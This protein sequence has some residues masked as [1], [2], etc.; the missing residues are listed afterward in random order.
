MT[1]HTSDH[2]RTYFFSCSRFFLVVSSLFLAFL[3]AACSL[4]GGST[5]TIPTTTSG[6]TPTATH[7]TSAPV[8]SLITYT[9]NGFRVGYP[10]RWTMEKASPSAALYRL[11]RPDTHNRVHRYGHAQP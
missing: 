2:H 3:L 8:T 4:G 9:G 1:N 10:A 5:G 7:P 6:N 11:Y